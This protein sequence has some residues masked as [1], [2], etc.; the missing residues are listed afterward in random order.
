MRV[1]GEGRAIQRCYSYELRDDGG[2]I[3]NNVRSKGRHIW[4]D[5]IQNE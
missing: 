5:K 1:A 4:T 2:P 3:A